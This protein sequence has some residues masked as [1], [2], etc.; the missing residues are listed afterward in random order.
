MTAILDTLLTEV[1]VAL[2]DYYDLPAQFDEHVALPLDTHQRAREAQA[3]RAHA[4]VD[5]ALAAG[6]AA[7]EL[8]SRL[9]LPG[10]LIVQLITDPV[11]RGEAW[12]AEIHHLERTAALVHRMR[13]R[14]IA[15]RDAAGEQK[16][17][18]AAEFGVSRPTL[19]KWIFDSQ[20]GWESAARSWLDIDAG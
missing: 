10:H 16:V 20:E 8:A 13:G 15:A 18:L 17:A 6:T 7:R 5:T 14:D 9:R 19:D 12:T 2:T 11:R 4:A 1:R 3:A